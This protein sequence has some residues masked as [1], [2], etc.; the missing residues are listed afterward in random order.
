MFVTAKVIWRIFTIFYVISFKRDIESA[1]IPVDEQG[2]S[3]TPVFRLILTSPEN[4]DMDVSHGE[5]ANKSVEP[6]HDK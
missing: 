1:I 3:H 2:E 6:G 4:Q 5:D